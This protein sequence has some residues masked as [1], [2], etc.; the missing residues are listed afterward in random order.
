MIGQNIKAI[1]KEKG[2]MQKELAQQIG[3]PAA[4]MS[5]YISGF[6][7]PGKERLKDIA[8][9]LECDVEELVKETSDDVYQ[10]G[11]KDTKMRS[12]ALMNETLDKFLSLVE[13]TYGYDYVRDLRPLAECMK[14]NRDE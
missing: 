10:F 12:D 9:I 1:L 8:R 5:N 14:G 4:R 6:R 13:D 11:F 7:N 3:I 2:M